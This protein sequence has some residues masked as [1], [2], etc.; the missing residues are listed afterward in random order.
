[1]LLLTRNVALDRVNS[2]LADA[3]GPLAG[4]PAKFPVL[5]PSFVHPPGGVCFDQSGNVCDRMR[6]RDAN[7]QM[8]VIGHAIDRDCHAADLADNSAE[9]GVKVTFDLGVDE[10]GAIARAEDE[11]DQQICGGVRLF[12][13]PSGAGSP[14]GHP[15]HGSRRGL[16]SY[17][18]S[19]L[20][21]P[22]SMSRWS[23]NVCPDPIRGFLLSCFTRI[24]HKLLIPSSAL[25][26]IRPIQAPILNRLGDVLGLDLRGA[27]EVGDS[28][29]NFQD[30]VVGA[31]A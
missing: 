1:M 4:L 26:P 29:C 17:A 23:V 24:L 15:T 25:R 10:R 14:G 3:E 20:T 18:A 30:A 2:R 19:R 7:Q 9:V 22:I 28:S 13:R 31:R 5:R 21:N 8:N 6:R 16:Y 12:F 11:M 27:F